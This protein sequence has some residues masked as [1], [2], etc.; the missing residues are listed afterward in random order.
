MQRLKPTRRQICSAAGLSILTGCASFEVA[1]NE[2]PQ[3]AQGYAAL[4]PR[5]V[6]GGLRAD[7]LDLQLL[8]LLPDDRIEKVFLQKVESHAVTLV[9]LAP[10]FYCLRSVGAADF[11]W[12]NEYA[13]KL[14]LFEVRAGVISYPGDWN[15][16][17]HIHGHEVSGSLTD[18]A[19]A[20]TRY[21]NSEEIINDPEIVQRLKKRYP[22]FARRLPIV[23]TRIQ[24]T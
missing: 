16:R 23:F 10:G 15:L 5:F 21:S 14:T 2:G 17:V 19:S 4:S 18:G 20:Q 12:V 22:L 3:P 11:Q 24:G 1:D 13:P 8:H 7:R 9:R 6:F